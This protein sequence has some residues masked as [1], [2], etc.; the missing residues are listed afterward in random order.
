VTAASRSTIA[1]CRSTSTMSTFT[2]CSAAD[3]S[4][5]N[6]GGG[7][8]VGP[9]RRASCYILYVLLIGND[10]ETPL[11]EDPGSLRRIRVGRRTI[12]S[13]ERTRSRPPNEKGAAETA[14][15]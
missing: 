14:T 4:R 8:D 7:G 3:H 1:S 15:P 2:L 11:F 10:S 13:M 5:G 6:A 12:L 9:R